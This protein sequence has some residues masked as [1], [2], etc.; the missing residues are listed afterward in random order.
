MGVTLLGAFTTWW[1][2]GYKGGAHV[3]TFIQS[4]YALCF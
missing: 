4:R 1:L 2:L 3:C